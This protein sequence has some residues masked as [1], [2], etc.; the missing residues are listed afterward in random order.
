M[1]ISIKSNITVILGVLSCQT[2]KN[3]F[4]RSRDNELNKGFEVGNA[5]RNLLQSTR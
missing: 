1:N 5:A 2:A 3:A 4:E